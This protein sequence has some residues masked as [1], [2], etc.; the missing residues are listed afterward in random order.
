MSG[1]YIH[2]I[3]S[4]CPIPAVWYME[5]FCWKPPAHP[6]HFGSGDSADQ[7]TASC[8]AHLLPVSLVFCMTDGGQCG[9]SAAGSR[10]HGQCTLRRS[11]LFGGIVRQRS[12]AFC[13]AKHFLSG[14]SDVGQSSSNAIVLR[15]LGYVYDPTAISS[16]IPR[17][18]YFPT[19][20]RKKNVRR[21]PH[22]ALP[23]III[24]FCC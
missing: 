20:I 2:V 4:S 15:G 24:C 13:H 14:S 1:T 17:N 19:V 3:E 12:E 23:E 6:C 11:C 7:A 5:T 8:K 18:D 21:I 16:F 22:D 10:R 9:V